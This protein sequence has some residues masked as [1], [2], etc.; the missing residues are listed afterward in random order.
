MSSPERNSEVASSHA[1]QSSFAPAIQLHYGPGPLQF[2]ELYVPDSTGPYPVV[3][4]IH[5][6]F[7]RARYGLSLMTGLARDLAER[8]IAAWNIEYRRIGDV[9][10]GWPGT[11]QDVD[12]A[13]DYLR[14]IAS[15]YALDSQRVVAVGHSAGGQLALWLA[16]RPH[17]AQDSAVA[18]SN[19]LLPLVGA[20]SLAGAIDLKHVWQLHLSNDVVVEFL[21]GTPNDVPE[22]YAV[23]S[24]A[25]LLPLG[26]PQVLIHGTADVNVPLV[27]SQAYA[28]KAKDA[29][30]PVTLIELPNAELFVVIKPNSAAWRT[31]VKEIR[32]MLKKM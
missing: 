21:G 2:G 11:L 5:G 6:G 30:D 13:T 9:G 22:R 32:K 19:T 15:A 31:T 8:G 7:W 27:V 12:L 16:A 3:T 20:I 17:I 4:L 14:T 10:G 25:A 26:V 18:V 29:G 28:R 23:A 1:T 24:P